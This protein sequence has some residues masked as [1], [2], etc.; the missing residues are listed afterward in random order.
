MLAA[1]NLAYEIQVSPYHPTAVVANEGAG[2][3]DRGGGSDAVPWEPLPDAGCPKRFPLCFDRDEENP[4][5]LTEVEI[6]ATF[7]K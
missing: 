7:S 2:E 4:P 3:G 1:R 5:I 6:P